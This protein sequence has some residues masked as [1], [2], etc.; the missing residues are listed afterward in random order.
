[1]AFTGRLQPLI[2]IALVDGEHLA[3]GMA[4]IWLWMQVII[5]HTLLAKASHKASSNFKVAEMY[6]PTMFLGW[7]EPKELP[8][9]PIFT[10][11]R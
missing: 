6:N 3:K 7:E 11:I 8:W 1:M 4:A 10:I 5:V 2:C 9:L